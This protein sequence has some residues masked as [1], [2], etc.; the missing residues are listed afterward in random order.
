MPEARLRSPFWAKRQGELPLI[1]AASAALILA[2]CA[3]HA[4]ATVNG[5]S[6]TMRESGLT[7]ARVIYIPE[8][9]GDP[10]H[11][12]LQERLIHSLHRRGES[13]MVG[14]EMIDVTQQAELDQYLTG[15]ISWSEFSRRTGFDR[16]W[17][18]TS[19]AYKRILT[20]CRE[21]DIPVIGLNAPPSVTRKIARDQK[22]TPAEAL[23]IPS[24]PEPPGGFEKF[25]AAMAG[26]PGIGSLRRYYEAQRAW[27]TTMAGRILAWL[28]EHPGTLV[29][30][31]GR[32]H[33][34]PTTGVP[35]Y[36]DKKAKT[37]QVIISPA[38]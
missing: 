28:S 9:H 8:E 27:D 5:S 34:D 20:W 10:S 11:H 1:W 26:H 21:N 33:A 36:V 3:A 18:K 25:K 12:Q 7:Q 30:L 14:M 2:G 17:G 4:P 37:T 19:P 23:L 31:L 15:R 38:K 32:Y 13:V 22:L 6:V 16:E 29:V 24:F 35:W